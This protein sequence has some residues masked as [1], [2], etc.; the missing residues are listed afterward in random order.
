LAAG[1]RWDDRDHAETVV[2]LRVQNR[3]RE[4]CPHGFALGTNLVE[5]FEKV[6]GIAKLDIR[7]EPALVPSGD[8]SLRPEDSDFLDRSVGEEFFQ[9]AEP[10]RLLQNLPEQPVPVRAGKAGS[11]NVD[12]LLDLLTGCLL[13]KSGRHAPRLRHVEPILELDQHPGLDDLKHRNRPG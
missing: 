6:V 9:R 3:H 8:H 13:E 11:L 7:W 5:H 1:R 2:Q 12:H 10:E 4:R